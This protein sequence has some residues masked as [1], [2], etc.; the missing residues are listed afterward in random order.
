MSDEIA[1]GHLQKRKIEAR[2]LIPFITACAFA[3]GRSRSRRSWSAPAVVSWAATVARRRGA[4]K[5]A[6][7]RLEG[8]E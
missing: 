6:I 2:V 7:L 4:D 3:D 8:L 5:S 1:I